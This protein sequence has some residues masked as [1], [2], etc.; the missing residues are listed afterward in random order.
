VFAILGEKVFL[1]L[2][3][4]AARTIMRDGRICF[5]GYLFTALQ[6]GIVEALDA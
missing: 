3:L 4:S 6:T 5:G 2:G 1:R